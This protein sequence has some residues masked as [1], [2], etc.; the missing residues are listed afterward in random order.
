[1]HPRRGPREVALV[2]DREEVCEL[3]QIHSVAESFN[4]IVTIG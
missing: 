3:A 1:M 4:L 2:G